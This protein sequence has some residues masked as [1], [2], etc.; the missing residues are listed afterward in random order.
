[1][2]RFLITLTFLICS[3]GHLLASNFWLS[4]TDDPNLGSAPPGSP[5][6]VLSVNH[7]VG[8]TTGSLFIWARP[9]S[10]KTLA[11]W[12]LNLVST[13]ANV[14]TFTGSSVEAFNV[15]DNSDPNTVR[16]EYVDEP[17]GD[18]SNLLDIEGFSLFGI[19]TPRIGVGIGPQSTGSPLDDS[20]YD[21]VND[22]WLLAQVDYTL[23]GVEEQT[24]IY[25][26][27]GS[28][29]LNMFSGTPSDPNNFLEPSA[30]TNAVFG[31]IS[32]PALNAATQRQLSSA[33]PDAT[34]ALGGVAEVA[35]FNGDSFVDGL[36]FLIWQQNAGGA[37]TLSTGDAN[38]DGQVNGLDLGIWELQYGGAALHGAVAVVPEPSGL[39]LCLIALSIPLFCRSN[40][41]KNRNVYRRR[42]LLQALIVAMG[43]PS[44]A[45]RAAISTN[46]NVTP[47]PAT[48]TLSNS[49]FIG[50]SSDGEMTVDGGSVVE[51]ATGWIGDD[52]N[53]MGTATIDGF[54]SAWTSSSS[55][56]VGDQGI[57]T[58]NVTS[59][60]TVNAQSISIAFSSGSSGQLT[61]DDATL[62]PNGGITVGIRGD[63]T[64]DI[65]NGGRVTSF[66]GTIGNDAGS[67][68]SVHVTDPNSDWTIDD[69]LEVGDEGNGNLL[70]SNG[71]SVSNTDL[72]YVAR[73]PDS[74]GSVVVDGA[75][76]TWTSAFNVL[77]GEE[78]H[79]SLDIT[80]GGQ[81]DVGGGSS[82]AF[83]PNSF[84]EVLV[85]GA[86]SL[87][88]M[89]VGVSVGRAGH[90]T[91]TISN[92][93]EVESAGG[94]IGNTTFGGVGSVVI[95]GPGAM[96]NADEYIT[97]PFPPFMAQATV[98]VN[99]GTLDIINGGLLNSP[100]SAT[101]GG[102][103]GFSASA[104]VAGT[105]SSWQ[106]TSL[107]VGRE[108]NGSLAI[109]NGGN[110]GST[111]SYIGRDPNSVGS[112]IVDGAGTIWN[113]SD[114][115]VGF[116]GSGTL[117]IVNGGVVNSSNGY[118][119]AEPGS[120]GTATVADSGSQ[121]TISGSLYVGG[122]S[123]GSGGTGTL[124]LD[125]GTVQASTVRIWETGE[126]R[127][128][129][130]IIG[131]VINCGLLSPGIGPAV[132]SFGTITIE[133]DYEQLMGGRLLIEIGSTDPNEFD[134][135]IVTGHATFSDTLEI[136][137]DDPNTLT[138]GNIFGSITAG[139]IS[140]E[141]DD[142]IAEGADDFY[143]RP[144]YA[145]TTASLQL[146]AEGDMNPFT[147]GLTEEDAVAFA[148][149][150]TDPVQYRNTYGVSADEA[151]DIDDLNGL[152]FDDIDDFVK[153]LN[154]ATGGS[155]SM[156]QMF[157][158]I[159]E[160]Q[161]V[162]EPT[163]QLQALCMVFVLLRLRR[164]S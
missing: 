132:P 79:G 136:V 86:G 44:I 16:W 37:G 9:D 123:G 48:T 70:I 152:D 100:G 29:G 94:G 129:G 36:D 112:V 124:I 122:D 95:D 3:C 155:M 121:W 18:N 58:L 38:G 106:S 96:W 80:N 71:A 60:G 114:L 74:S 12:S 144:I 164:R 102:S 56:L 85:D 32:D 138:V 81:V 105:G 5:G 131:N 118:I 65:V 43:Y 62:D 91:L 145:A 87:W 146:F 117:E 28:E 69:R 150:L 75:N 154:E 108:G 57:G 149:A 84:G 46:G 59:G 135:L 66:L 161:A 143:F 90:G 147:P 92:G 68:G 61:V 39:M 31:S 47:N 73:T 35:N 20:F 88:S 128:S 52:P 33:T 51:S 158:I 134:Q 115:Y 98:S 93:A 109:T 160:V 142:V 156:T 157:R 139:S 10:G 141:F 126:V 140:G 72:A 103:A 13:N 34:I 64:M 104:T 153:L 97:L 25:L 116:E 23:T 101:I 55:I 24:E 42:A 1:M 40:Y 11:N 125:G 53:V 151:G 63:G 83:D 110:V 14:L 15:L 77:I 41:G 27:I 107:T 137:V 120:T 76:S 113:T 130:T 99:N 111:T 82:I 7:S 163:S 22:A 17:G 78:G 162:P 50:D 45:A 67:T 133:G 19:G 4:T 49:L 127:G 21:P 30:S 148:L 2:S 119:A 54:G 8:T 26:Q 159:E 6:S 89:A